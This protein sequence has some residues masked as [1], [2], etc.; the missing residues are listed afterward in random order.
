MGWLYNLQ[1]RLGFVDDIWKYEFSEWSP[2]KG[3]RLCQ[4]D[5]GSKRN[6]LYTLRLHLYNC[7][8]RLCQ[9]PNQAIYYQVEARP[10]LKYITDAAK[11]RKSE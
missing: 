2:L 6:R 4:Q 10:N 11:A 5:F 9:D 7:L 3:K 1:A 8:S